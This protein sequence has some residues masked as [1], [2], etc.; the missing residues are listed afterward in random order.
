MP[1]SEEMERLK[2]QSIQWINE[3]RH[4]H[5]LTPLVFDADLCAQA[6]EHV[7]FMNHQNRLI[8]TSANQ[9]VASTYLSLTIEL[10]ISFITVWMDLNPDILL[11]PTITKFGI[12]FYTNSYHMTY[13]TYYVSSSR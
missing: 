4:S 1:S 6:D 13:F 8:A 3:I 11:N 12:S 9:Q 5:S 2:H 7:L 10:L